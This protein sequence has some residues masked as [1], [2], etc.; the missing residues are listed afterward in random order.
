[1]NFFLVSPRVLGGERKT[2]WSIVDVDG[3]AVMAWAARNS[4]PN[5]AY[6]YSWNNYIK[7]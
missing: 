6:A 5:H 4:N 1:M 2:I 3:V 7:A